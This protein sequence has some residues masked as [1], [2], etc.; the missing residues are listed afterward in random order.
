M[1]DMEDM[2]GWK[3]G[4][5]EAKHGSMVQHEFPLGAN[6]PWQKSR[7]PRAGV[8]GL[9][10]RQSLRPEPPCAPN[11]PAPKGLRRNGTLF[12]VADSSQ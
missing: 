2:E 6:S 3:H 7:L 8:F 10:A 12:V 11:P 1:E 4:S 9:Q 5:M